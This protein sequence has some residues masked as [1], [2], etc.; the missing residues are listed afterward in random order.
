MN[1]STITERLENALT[2]GGF[3]CKDSFNEDGEEITVWK[4]LKTGQKI[5]V[6]YEVFE[7][8]SED[9]DE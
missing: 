9:D 5:R 1:I 3:F 2:Q 4:E 8:E 6:S 7:E